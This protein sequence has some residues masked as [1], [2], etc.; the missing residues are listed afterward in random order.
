[1]ILANDVHDENG[2]EIIFDINEVSSVEETRTI[3]SAE[4]YL[5]KTASLRNVEN[6]V[7]SITVYQIINGKNGL[8][9]YYQSIDFNSYVTSLIYFNYLCNRDTRLEYLDSQNVAAEYDGWLHFNTTIVLVT[10]THGIYPN[11]GLYVKVQPLDEGKLFF[12]LSNSY[13]LL[14]V[15][16]AVISAVNGAM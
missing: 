12:K 11:R 5:Y 10:W 8:V 14:V 13:R 4:V 3:M 7:Y 16:L 2:F 9:N 6:G 15:I 1:M